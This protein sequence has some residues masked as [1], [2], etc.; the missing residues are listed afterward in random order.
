MTTMPHDEITVRM[1][2]AR[3]DSELVDFSMTGLLVAGLAGIMAIMAVLY[4]APAVGLPRIDVIRLAGTM[5]TE[6]FAPALITGM[7]LWVG[8]GML[9]AVLY[10]ALWTRGVTKPDLK[11]G[12]LIG[13]IHGN[14][15]MALFP[16]FLAV[17]P[18]THGMTAT[19]GA[20]IVLILAHLVFG[21]VMALVYRQYLEH[22][23]GG[24]HYAGEMR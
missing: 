1:H 9:F 20:G 19:I 24:H 11:G 13:L 17:H 5:F 12:L 4:C 7:L 3:A 15:V 21:A 14:I 8:I 22:P 18:L 2:E 16:V 10:V 23:G 6:Q